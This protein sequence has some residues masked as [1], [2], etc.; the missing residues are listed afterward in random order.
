MK[1][2][3]KLLHILD[4]IL[5]YSLYCLI[6]VTIFSRALIELLIVIIVLVWIVKKVFTKSFS[7]RITSPVFIFPFLFLISGFLSLIH[8]SHLSASL[9]ELFNMIEFFLLF[10]VVADE[11]ATKE[12]LQKLILVGLCAGIIIAL[13]GIFQFFSGKDFIRLRPCG[14]VEGFSRLTAS[15]SHPNNL[16]GYIAAIFPVCF[17]SLLFY[18]WT[19]NNYAKK[20]GLFITCIILLFVCAMTYSRGAWIAL[21]MGVALFLIIRNSKFFL[22]LI[23]FL[24]FISFF[25]PDFL[26]NRVKDIVNIHNITSQTRLE[27]WKKAIEMIALHPVVGNGLKSFS[28]IYGEGYTHNCYLQILAETGLIGFIAYLGTLFVFIYVNIK[29]YFKNKNTQYRLFFLGF[30]GS[31]TAYG[32]HSLIDTNLFSMPL[33]VTFWFLLGANAALYNLSKKEPQSAQRERDTLCTH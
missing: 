8:S 3:N 32:T 7:L 12:R 11:T 28:R 19:K 23:V 9:R 33:A 27:S 18:T 16:G 4:T 26:V 24:L 22:L 31:L 6:V 14:D 2:S 25:L 29:S 1:I 13:D 21:F 30:A 15:F 20:T 5:E 17:L 10:C